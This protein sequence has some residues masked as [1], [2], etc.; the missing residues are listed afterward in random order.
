MILI[1]RAAQTPE[2][3]LSCPLPALVLPRSRYH[4][5]LL[6]GN[7]ISIPP[8]SASLSQ[9]CNYPHIDLIKAWLVVAPGP[10]PSLLFRCLWDNCDDITASSWLPGG[11]RLYDAC[12]FAPLM[13][14]ALGW[15]LYYWISLYVV[16]ES[17][18]RRKQTFWLHFDSLL[19]RL[20][21]G[22]RSPL[23]PRI[24]TVK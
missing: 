7:D 9:S 20:L 23:S 4:S 1:Q 10:A 3:G 21:L 8:D 12:T 13:K 18:R 19:T 24:R 2:N 22:F 17:Q 15:T 11:Q 5:H 14:L 6:D 16:C